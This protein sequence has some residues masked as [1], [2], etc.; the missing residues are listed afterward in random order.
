MINPFGALDRF[1]HDRTGRASGMRIAGRM[2]AALAVLYLIDQLLLSTCL[3][4]FMSPSSGIIP[5]RMAR[6]VSLDYPKYQRSL[7]EFFPESDAFLWFVWFVGLVHGILLLLGI[8][9]RWQL[10]G[11]LVNLASFQ[12]QNGIMW[13]WCVSCFPSSCTLFFALG[14]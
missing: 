2:R 10:L 9:S 3:N 11:I 14:N 7:L 12:H 8:A 13:D 1:L 6:E 4:E 5:T